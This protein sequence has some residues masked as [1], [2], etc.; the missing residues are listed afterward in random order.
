MFGGTGAL[1]RM[2]VGPGIIG[3]FIVGG[4]K[5]ALAGTGGG[6]GGPLSARMLPNLSM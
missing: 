1:G 5:T 6:N 3:A 4:I 2:N